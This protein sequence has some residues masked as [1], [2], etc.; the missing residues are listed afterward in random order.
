MQQHS[1]LL[2]KERQRAAALGHEK[3]REKYKMKHDPPFGG[4]PLVNL[5]LLFSSWMPAVVSPLSMSGLL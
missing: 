4:A 5:L 1:A 2:T 3:L